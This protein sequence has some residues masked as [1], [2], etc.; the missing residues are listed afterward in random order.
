M[1]NQIKPQY[2]RPGDIIGIYSPSSGI[3]PA[4]EVNYERGKKLLVDRG[5]ELREALHSRDW[6]AHYSADG[7]T[8]AADFISL[9]L[10]QE[11]KA[12]LP[13]VGG[14]TA[15]QMLPYIDYNE[16]R[17]HP[18][19]IFGFSDNSLQAIV[20]TDKTGLV[21]FHG[22]SDIVFG[23]GDLGDEK[24]MKSFSEEGTYTSMQFFNALEGRLQPGP[25]QKATPW[26]VLKKGTAEGKLLGGNLDVLQILHGTRFAVDWSGAIFFWEAA[27]VELHRV[28]LM[29][30]SFAMTGVLEKIHGMVVGKGNN[31]DEQFFS[32]KHESLE[33]MIL[34]HCAPYDFPIIVDADIGHDIE[35][36]AL[37]VGVRARVDCDSLIILESPYE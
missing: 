21:T 16:I 6:N 28:D 37:P 27:F 5:Y 17:R 15:Y 26:R 10:D 31:L 13:T 33:E 20:I 36:C 24:K 32:E 14:T 18:K 34:R 2:L 4:L 19:M 11:V 9:L 12:I 30:A 8:K 1:T 22:H 7:I 23:I 29:L 3:E 25:I 35:C